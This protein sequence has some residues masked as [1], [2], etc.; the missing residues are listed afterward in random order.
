MK[1]RTKFAIALVLVMLVLSTVVLGSVELFKRQTVDDERQSINETANLTAR[2]I[3]STVETRREEV[4]LF[5][6]QDIDDPNATGTY[7]PEF[8]EQTP[9]FAAQT[10]SANGT[11]V[12]FRGGLPAEQREAAIGTYVGN[13]S[14]V[15]AALGGDV[16][17]SDPERVEI[18]S[19]GVGELTR[20]QRAG[21]AY[22]RLCD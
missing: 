13:R 16:A 11:V 3:E 5:A 22:I 4:R 8:V 15:A 19:S 10:V 18:V 21:A 6:A 14:H 17:V 20:L 12:D 1:L 2:Q 9:F 7:L